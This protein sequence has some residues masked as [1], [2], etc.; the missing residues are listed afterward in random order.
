M[1]PFYVFKREQTQ[2]RYRNSTH[3]L[4]NDDLKIEFEGHSDIQ[5]EMYQN[6]SGTIQLQAESLHH[7]II[8]SLEN[9]HGNV[10][11]KALANNKAPYVYR[12]D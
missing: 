6:V 1:T 12:C 4:N 7:D 8:S 10:S 11:Y 3:R 5:K 2:R 9:T